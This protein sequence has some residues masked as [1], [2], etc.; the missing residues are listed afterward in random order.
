MASFTTAEAASYPERPITFKVGFAPGGG[1]DVL[2]RK[3]AERLNKI[4]PQPII[5]M[6]RD[7]AASTIAAAEVAKAR[8]D[9]YT[10]LVGSSA[11]FSIS[12]KLM[13]VQY[14]PVKSFEPIAMLAE[15]S[16]AIVV[17]SSLQVQ[18]LQ[19]FIDLAKAKPGEIYYGSAGVGSSAHIGVEGFERSAGI[20]LT[21]VPY[22]GSAPAKTALLGGEVS[23]VIDA[24]G[25]A[26]EMSQSGK[27]KILAT[28]GA[29]RSPL[30]PDVPTLDEAGVKGFDYSDWY[31]LFAPAG[32][33]P[34]VV[35][36]LNEAVNQALS[37]KDTVD[38]L[39][40]QGFRVLSGS[41]EDLKKVKVDDVARRGAL[42]DE[43]GIK[44]EN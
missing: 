24:V 2:A 15:L 41:P 17:N 40:K 32:T 19:Q 5:V 23:F 27:A 14:D 20:K 26:V 37:D 10:I 43:A 44:I 31:A 33:P 4:L 16:Y 36:Q 22:K 42:I 11:A 8:P 9:G 39:Q 25:S 6:N 13:S 35:K 3:V 18:T 38:W 29:K 28:L 1:T 7:G 30:L 21:H 12:P 34:D